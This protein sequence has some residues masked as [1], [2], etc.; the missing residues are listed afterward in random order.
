MQVE[1]NKV[2]Y[3]Y[4]TLR[5]DSG[6]LF[7]S[8]AARKPLRILVGHH[9]VIPGL[10]KAI[11]G[12]K[13]GDKKD[14]I[15]EPMDAY[16][17]KKDKLVKAYPRN[18]IPQNIALYIGRTLGVK[19]KNGRKLKVVVKSFNETEVVLDSNHPIAGEKLN[20][21]TKIVQIRDATPRELEMEMAN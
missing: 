19:K 17:F 12:M 5:L 10:E 13:V 14:G 8:T 2:V 21:R 11:M 18:I 3:F 1:K 4:Y 16:G 9:Q 7:D 6:E 15:I 20:F